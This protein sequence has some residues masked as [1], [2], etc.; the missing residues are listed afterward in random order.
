MLHLQGRI[1][2]C[3][4]DHCTFCCWSVKACMKNFNQSRICATIIEH[5]TSYFLI[6][7]FIVTFTVILWFCF[8]MLNPWCSA[9]S[10]GNFPGVKVWPPILSWEVNEVSLSSEFF[11][12][13]FPL[14]NLQQTTYKPNEIHKF[15]TLLTG[16]K[17]TWCKLLNHCTE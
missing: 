16:Y 15:Y 13:F 8:I 2:C 9:I 14:W 11:L 1:R 3:A 7:L 10:N 6:N 12:W 17:A 4:L 5:D